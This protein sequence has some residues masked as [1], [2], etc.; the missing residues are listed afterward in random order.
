MKEGIIGRYWYYSLVVISPND[1][2]H[3]DIHAD[4]KF[5]GKNCRIL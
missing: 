5:G 2:E 1:L 4:A 3:N